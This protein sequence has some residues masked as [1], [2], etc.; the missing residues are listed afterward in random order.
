MYPDEIALVERIP[1][2]G[3]RREITWGEFDERADS[4]RSRE[5]DAKHAMRN[6]GSPP[7]GYMRPARARFFS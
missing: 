4:T 5:I 6:G 3:K 7:S 2:E 1:A